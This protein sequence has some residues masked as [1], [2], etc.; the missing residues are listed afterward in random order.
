MLQS[1]P[2]GV[3]P[4]VP[5]VLLK[6]RA[7]RRACD[8]GSSKLARQLSNRNQ[9]CGAPAA[10]HDAEAVR[11]QQVVEGILV[12]D[13]KEQTRTRKNQMNRRSLFQR[14]HLPEQ[15]PGVSDP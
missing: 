9:R 1:L 3:C 14:S 4:S 10:T 5:R 13:S 7:I 2:D 11:S 6:K 12:A 8:S 15:F